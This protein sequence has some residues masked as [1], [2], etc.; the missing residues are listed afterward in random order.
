[1][2]LEDIVIPALGEQTHLVPCNK[3]LEFFK[4]EGNISNRKWFSVQ[5]HFYFDG[6]TNKQNAHNRALQNP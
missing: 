5:A 6:Y 1:M 2:S 4:N 3:F